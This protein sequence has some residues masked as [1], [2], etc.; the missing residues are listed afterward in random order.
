[1]ADIADHSQAGWCFGSKIGECIMFGVHLENVGKPHFVDIVKE[2]WIYNRLPLNDMKNQ[3]KFMVKHVQ[4]WSLA[5][6]GTYPRWIHG[7]YLAAIAAFYA[8]YVT[9]VQ[10]FGFYSLHRIPPVTATVRKL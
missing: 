2:V 8:K 3:Y 4:L 6:H 5:F 7:V 10:A 9:Q 1:M